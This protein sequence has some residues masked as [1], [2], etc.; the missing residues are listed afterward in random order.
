MTI[1]TPTTNTISAEKLS[2]LMKQDPA[3]RILDVRTGGEFETTHIPGSCNVPL[4]TLAEHVQELAKV[5]HPVVLVCQSGRRA[6][7]AHAKLAE[8]GKQSLNILEGGMASW[9]ASG[10]EITRGNKERW[11]MDRQVRFVAG[12]IALAGIIASIVV[13]QAKWIAG[14]VAAGLVFSAATNTCAMAAV[15]SKFPYNRTDA[16]DIDGILRELNSTE[17]TQPS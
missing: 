13:P 4:D 12:L 17:G 10:G 9:Q 5:K 3:L 15:I 7:E 8:A 2:E 14:A 11:A 16:C 1:S 6:T